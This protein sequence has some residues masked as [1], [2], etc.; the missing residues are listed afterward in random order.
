[1]ESPELCISVG[2]LLGV[3]KVSLSGSM[4]DWHDQAVLGVLAGFRDQQATS[5]VLD[6]VGLRLSGIDG[7]AGL[8]SVLRSLGPGMCVHIVAC[9]AAKAILD[10]AGLGPS[11]RLYSS[12]DELAEYVLAQGE[13]LTSRWM[14]SGSEDAELPMAA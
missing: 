6:I 10:K 12:T 7:A 4:H 1:M 11:A 9:G 3:P 5:L 2:E 14:V 8:I 13:Y